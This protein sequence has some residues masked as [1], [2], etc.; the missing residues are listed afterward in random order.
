MLSGSKKILEIRE[1]LLKIFNGTLKHEIYLKFVG[2]A[3]IYIT[4]TKNLLAPVN[5]LKPKSKSKPR[6]FE[7]NE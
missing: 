6:L 5:L 3:N 2:N 1:G 7:S 4:T